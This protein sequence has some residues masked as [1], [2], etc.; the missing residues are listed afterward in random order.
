[1]LSTES[2]RPAT[3]LCVA[4]PSA[5]SGPVSVEATQALT[6]FPPALCKPQVR[7]K[8][9]CVVFTHAQHPT[10]FA[11]V[12]MPLVSERGA[13][14][15][16]A[17]PPGHRGILRCFLTCTGRQRRDVLN[18]KDAVDRLLIEFDKLSDVCPTTLSRAS[19]AASSRPPRAV[20]PRRA[21]R[22]QRLTRAPLPPPACHGRCLPCASA[23]GSSARSSTTTATSGSRRAASPALAPARLPPRLPSPPRRP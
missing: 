15:S 12:A 17:A 9:H 6:A 20:A 1:M 19:P 3:F 22:V 7:H 18:N 10:V 16:A 11:A 5:P 8:K 21:R 2:R 4:S 14:S 13:A 23:T